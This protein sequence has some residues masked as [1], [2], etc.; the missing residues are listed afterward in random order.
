MMVYIIVF[1]ICRWIG[2]EKIW[3]VSIPLWIV[4][5]L[6]TNRLGALDLFTLGVS[7]GLMGL[8]ILARGRV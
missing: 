6:I 4:A 8:I 3:L 2:A 5:I 1:A 7:V